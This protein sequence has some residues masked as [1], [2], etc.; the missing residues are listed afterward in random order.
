MALGTDLDGFIKPTLA[1]LGDM[2]ELA[3]LEA[4]LADRY[5]QADAE[6]IASAN[7]LRVLRTAW[8]RP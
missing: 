4:L 6:R 1:G 3:R 8:R 5:G 7:V 2:R